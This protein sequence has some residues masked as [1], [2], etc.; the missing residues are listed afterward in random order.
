[1]IDRMRYGFGP[2]LRRRGRGQEIELV[3]EE[4]GDCGPFGEMR[5]GG[6]DSI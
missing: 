4:G 1:M 2:P 6:T 3:Q 5:P